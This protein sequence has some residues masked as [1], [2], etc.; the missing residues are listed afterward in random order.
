M[1]EG[2]E[3]S[4]ALHCCFAYGLGWFEKIA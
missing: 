1:Q 3:A 4:I 2:P